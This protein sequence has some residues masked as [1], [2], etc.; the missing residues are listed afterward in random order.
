MKVFMIGGTGLL[1]SAAAMELIKKGHNVVSLALPPIPKNA[2]IPNEMELILKNYMDLSDLEIFELLKDCQGFI[3]AAGIDER[4]EG[5]PPIYEL[6]N[7]YNIE[8]L[9]RL[10]PL[11]K[12]AGVKHSVILGSYF[13]YFNRVWSDLNLYNK[14][15]YI[16]SRV[17][18]EN[19][20]LSYAD[21]QMSVS[22]LEL[23]YIFG[24][25]PGRR[26]VWTILVEQILKMRK[27]TFYPNGGTSMIS[28]TQVGCLISEVLEK[29]EGK[30]LIPVGYYNLTWNQ[31]IVEF[32][33]ALGINRRIINIPKWIY[34]LGLGSYIKKYKNEGHEQ[35]LNL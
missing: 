6:Y 21:D 8:P 11:A 15:P 7:K 26:P 30:N 10:L 17:D 12:Q 29:P 5:K 34:K 16:R 14:H 24:I 28:V 1:G 13:S 22:V 19:I 32:H 9:K 2:P 25:Q 35:G 20:A 3:F 33:K 23:P 4:V 27:W 31:M 18:Q